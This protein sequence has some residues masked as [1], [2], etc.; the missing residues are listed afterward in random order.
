[1][2]WNE[3]GK[4]VRTRTYGKIEQSSYENPQKDIEKENMRLKYLIDDNPFTEEPKGISMCYP[5]F[6]EEKVKEA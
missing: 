2:F 1:L 5:M 4:I 3:E 6:N